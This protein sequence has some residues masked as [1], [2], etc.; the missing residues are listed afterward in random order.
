MSGRAS[1]KCRSTSRPSGLYP[2]RSWLRNFLVQEHRHQR[3]AWAA[4]EEGEGAP[5]WG[6]GAAFRC[7]TLAMHGLHPI[8]S[9]VCLIGGDGR[10]SRDELHEHRGR[11]RPNSSRSR[12]VSIVLIV[13]QC[14]RTPGNRNHST[15]FTIY[16]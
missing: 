16:L 11:T 12:P 2:G 15:R 1:A 9:I 10:R 6:R 13:S 7:V 5:A 8:T 14:G 3:G 4:G